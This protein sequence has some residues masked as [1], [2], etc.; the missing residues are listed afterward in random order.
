MEE[1]ESYVDNLIKNNTIIFWGEITPESGREFVAELF[2]TAYRIKPKHSHA[3]VRYP[4]KPDQIIPLEQTEDCPRITVLLN[5]EGGDAYSGLGMYHAIRAV[6]S[7]GIAV[8]VH[9]QARAFSSGATVFQAAT[10]RFMAEHSQLIVHDFLWT[11][12]QEHL[13]DQMTQQ[14]VCRRQLADILATR[15]TKGLND[16]D[17]WVE[18]LKTYRNQLY[19]AQE[20]VDAGLADFVE[21]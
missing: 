10:R 14:D 4:D 2:D 6:R 21:V 3:V 9:V 8:D 19:T 5:T 15:N 16:P 12:E 17:Y 1:V 18:R 7:M 13:D 11:L 20:A